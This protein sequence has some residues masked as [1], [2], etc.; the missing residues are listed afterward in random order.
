CLNSI[1]CL[2]TSHS[3]TCCRHT[4]KVHNRSSAQVVGRQLHQQIAHSCNRVIFAAS[5][6]M[7]NT[8]AHGFF[9]TGISTGGVQGQFPFIGHHHKISTGCDHGRRTN[10]RSE[11]QCDLRHNTGQVI[12]GQQDFAVSCHHS[13]TFI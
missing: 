13:S 3:G 7:A 1:G 8:S 4:G 12:A 6:D 2:H 9:R 5:C 11:H 10:A